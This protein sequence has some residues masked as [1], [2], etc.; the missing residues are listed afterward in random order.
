MLTTTPAYVRWQSATPDKNCLTE[1]LHQV[2]L[3]SPPSQPNLHTS[4]ALSL[5]LST[6]LEEC[7]PHVGTS[8][9][10]VTPPVFHVLTHTTLRPFIY[11]QDVYHHHSYTA[12]QPPIYHTVV[13]MAHLYD[14]AFIRH[15]PSPYSRSQLR[16]YLRRISWPSLSSS[17]VDD[18]SI[19]VSLEFVA[20][21]ENLSQLMFLH[22]TTFAAENTDI[23]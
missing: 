17:N 19:D 13:R 5:I 16:Q 8:T 7:R 10:A 20:N 18:K 3:H 15:V 4:P 14:Q 11:F 12:E 1:Q 22:C 2:L 6:F 21:V 23:H 9:P